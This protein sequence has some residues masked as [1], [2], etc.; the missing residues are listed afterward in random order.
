MSDRH[1][2]DLAA[3]C[4]LQRAL[5]NCKTPAIAVPWP[6]DVRGPARVPEIGG[7]GERVPLNLMRIMPPQGSVSSSPSCLR[8]LGSH[9]H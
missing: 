7:A 2:Q 4:P 8:S 1:G 5:R 3:G 9:S 6:P